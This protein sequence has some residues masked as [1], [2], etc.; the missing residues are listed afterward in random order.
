MNLSVRLGAKFNG[1]E[2]IIQVFWQLFLQMINRT[3]RCENMNLSPSVKVL[4]LARKKIEKIH[5]FKSLV[6]KPFR[7]IKALILTDCTGNFGR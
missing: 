1:A 3:K 4:L 6:Q 7:N 5:M 2:Y